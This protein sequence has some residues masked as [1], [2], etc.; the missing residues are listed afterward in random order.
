[1]ANF[2]RKRP[3][4]G[5]TDRE[6]AAIESFGHKTARPILTVAM[7]RGGMLSYGVDSGLCRQ[8]T[9]TDREA[10]VET[11]RKMLEERKRT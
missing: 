8:L 9:D 5:Q 6:Y 10:I 3:G 7:E 11:V 4:M 2:A 1:M